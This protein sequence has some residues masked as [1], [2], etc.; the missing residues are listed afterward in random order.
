MK[1]RYPRLR[2]AQSNGLHEYAARYAKEAIR[3]YIQTEEGIRN[4][5]RQLISSFGPPC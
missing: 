3:A 1:R 4:S 5:K 2:I